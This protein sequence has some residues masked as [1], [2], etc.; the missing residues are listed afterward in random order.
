MPAVT[1]KPPGV[2]SSTPMSFNVSRNGLKAQTEY[3][4]N[5]V[6]ARRTDRSPTMSPVAPLD[7]EK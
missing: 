1:E 5:E 3:F 7:F 2:S 4:Q 6:E